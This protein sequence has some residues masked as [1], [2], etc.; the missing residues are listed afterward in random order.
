MRQTKI[1]E[2]ENKRGNAKAPVW[3]SCR[4]LRICVCHLSFRRAVMLSFQSKKERKKRER[5]RERE[6]GRERE[7]EKTPPYTSTS[8]LAKPVTVSETSFSHAEV[9]GRGTEAKH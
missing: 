1:R 9:T 4:S 3:E 8:P 7:R 2:R 5:E 6:G